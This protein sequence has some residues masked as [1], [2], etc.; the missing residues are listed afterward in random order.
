MTLRVVPVDLDDPRAR[1]LLHNYANEISDRHDGAVT[2]A[3]IDA[4]DPD[5]FTVP[6]GRFLLATYNGEPVG[7][8]GIRLLDSTT[9]EVKRMHVAAEARGRGIGKRLLTELERAARHQGADTICLDTS[10]RLTEAQSLYR[11]AGY[12][13]VDRYNTNPHA[14]HWFQKSLAPY[15]DSIIDLLEGMASFNDL[16]ADITNATLG[17]IELRLPIASRHCYAPG[18]VQAGPIMA[19]GDYAAGAACFT[20]LPPGHV[21][22]TVNVHADILRAAAGQYLSAVGT[23]TKEGRQLSVGTA[24]IYAHQDN[25]RRHVASVTATMLNTATTPRPTS[26]ADAFGRLSNDTQAHTLSDTSRGTRR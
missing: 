11:N 12:D 3:E 8:G 5:E 1:H 18:Q 13:P 10:N 4:N 20:H 6:N 24:D 7:C 21:N 25:T 16:G 14:T 19:L 17:A 22:S 23:V 15:N 26:E 2:A 9:A